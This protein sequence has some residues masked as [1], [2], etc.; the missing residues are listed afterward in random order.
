M[1]PTSKAEIKNIDH[2]G[3]VAGLIDEIGI[4]ETINSKLGIDPREKISARILVKAIIINGLGFV[5]RPLYLFSQFFEDKGIEILLG[6]GVKSDYINDDKIGRVMD[7]LYKYGLNNLFIEIVLSVIKK[8]N[9]DTK[10]SHLDATSFHL[11]GEYKTDK[12][13]DKEEKIIKERPIIITKGYSRDHRPDLKQVVLDLITSSDGDIP[14]L[15][16]AGDGNEADKAVFGKI[17]VEFKKQIVFDSI[18]VCDSALYSQENLKL[19]EHLKWISRVPMTIK[20]AQELVESV[21]IEEISAEE[22]EKRASQNLDGYKWKEEIVNYG[23]IKQVWLIVESQKRKDSDLEK[24]DKKLKKEK[25][26]VEKLLKELKKE[27]FETP[28]QARYKLKGINKKLKLFEIKEVKLIESISKDKKIIYKMEGVGYEKPEEIEIQRKEAGRFILAT[29]LV[30]ENKLEPEEIITTYKNQQ[31]CE[32][33]FR[34][35]KGPLFFAD[36][37]F[38]ENPERIET[39]LFL[40]S[41]CLLV[42]NLGQRELR[43]SLKRIKIGIKNQL[44]KLTICPTLRW[45]FQ[46][47]QGIHLLTLN[48][49]NQII[50]LTSE[51]HFI[52]NCL[53]SSCQKY[54]LLS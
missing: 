17:L 2:L 3:I 47:F 38:V 35:L 37:F 48:G 19:I 6:E 32:I 18:M 16:R 40:M 1:S 21:E 30:D 29:N 54:Y 26:K 28:E 36:S 9:I 52:L 42:Y 43:N 27:D 34:F 11:H 7:K 49:I 10:Y 13:K 31:S 5:S 12:N 51:R 39:M 45:V 25:D 33:G 14:L 22:R 50:N 53:P 4:V 24:L 23:G 44:G 41:L 15:M 8:F 20:K 46:C